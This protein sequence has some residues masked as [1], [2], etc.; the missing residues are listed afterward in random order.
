MRFDQGFG[1]I[2]GDDEF[3]Y[4]F[5]IREVSGG[6][7]TF[8]RLTPGDRVKFFKSSYQRSDADGKDY[9]VAFAAIRVRVQQ[10]PNLMS[11][12]ITD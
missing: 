2:K 6:K 7:S 4:F 5:H 8:E 10:Q 12:L 1:F 9:G 3:E 11:D